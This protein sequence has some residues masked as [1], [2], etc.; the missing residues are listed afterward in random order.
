MLAD[1]RSRARDGGLNGPGARRRSLMA[2]GHVSEAR[3]R[4]SMRPAGAPAL[5]RRGAGGARDRPGGSAQRQ[6]P[7]IPG[8]RGEHRLDSDVI[9]APAAR[10]AQATTLLAVAEDRLDQAFRCWMRRRAG[11]VRRYAAVRSRR[12]SSSGL[13]TERTLAV[14]QR[15][16]F[17]GHAAQSDGRGR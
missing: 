17:S 10:P 13:D 12:P 7:D 6:L 16:A 14:P 8:G 2:L 1:V 11:R 3:Q 5:G 15:A 9:E 4:A